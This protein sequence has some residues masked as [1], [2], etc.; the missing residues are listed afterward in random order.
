MTPAESRSD[1]GPMLS[2]RSTCAVASVAPA[3]SRSGPLAVVR[4]TVPQSQPQAESESA[5]SATAT[6]RGMRASRAQRV[7]VTTTR[8]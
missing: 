8:P 3:A 1:D 6:S 4:L 2:L 5:A 7:T